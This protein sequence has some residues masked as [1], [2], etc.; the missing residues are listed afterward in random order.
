MEKR[1][2]L[3]NY[4]C[5]RDF[6]AD[7]DRWAKTNLRGYSR[8]AFA[9]WGN[10]ESPN[11]LTLVIKGQRA[12]KGQWLDGFI[13]AA[14]LE[15]LDAKYLKLLSQFENT[16]NA[17]D[18]G[19]VLEEIKEHLKDHGQKS[20][21]GD[22]LE[23]LTNPVAWT[24]YH[25][26]DLIDHSKSPI[27]FKKRIRFLNLDTEKIIESI[28]ILKRIGLIKES[29]SSYLSL[30][31]QLYS[32]DQIQKDSNHRFHKNIL[33][34]SL[35]ALE[36]LE[37]SERSFGSLTATVRED[38]ISELKKEVGKFGQLLLK[39]YSSKGKV[40]GEVYRMNIQLYPLT[41]K[42]SE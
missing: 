21:A 26:M 6:V 39:K 31:H 13:K 19:L 3:R 18:R 40:E 27:W 30:E 20:I 42:E 33:E 8:R 34:E 37:P 24:V 5:I 36:N 29:E 11:F 4:L 15:T 14:G 38:Q 35:N 17:D 32:P 12:L 23:I 9:R 10:I 22:Q 2:V 16:R 28:S 7:F 1:P 41:K 25:M